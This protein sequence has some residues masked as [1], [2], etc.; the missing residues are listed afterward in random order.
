[1]RLDDRMMIEAAH[2]FLGLGKIYIISGENHN[3]DANPQV[4]WVI[5]KKEECLELTRFLNRHILLS[6]KANEYI[7]WRA[8]VLELNKPNRERNAEKIAMCK[9]YLEKIRRYGY[10][11]GDKPDPAIRVPPNFGALQITDGPKPHI[12]HSCFGSTY[13]CGNKIP[14]DDNGIWLVDTLDI[15]ECK[16][17]TA[18]SDT[19]CKKCLEIFRKR[20]LAQRSGSTLLTGLY[21]SN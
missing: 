13:L 1:M 5:V 18:M 16:I 6:K 4:N 12:I 3:P 9:R 15:E 20:V 2:E 14:V 19:G 7:Y 8:A 17:E 21:K 11:L 10:L